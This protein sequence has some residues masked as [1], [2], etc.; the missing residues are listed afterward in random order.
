MGASGDE[1][2]SGVTMNRTGSI[3]ATG[4]IGHDNR[5]GTVRVYNANANWAQA[6][7]DIDGA[8]GANN[9]ESGFSISMNSSGNVIAIGSPGNDK[10]GATETGLDA[11]EE[12]ARAMGIDPNTFYQ[13]DP[14]QFDTIYNNYKMTVAKM[15]QKRSEDAKK[16]S[17]EM[18][19]A[20]PLDAM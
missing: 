3:I 4:A 10:T 7:A 11:E 16:A 19:S 17:G 5:R 15:Q 20:V 9:D 18:R 14:E 12:V 1:L 2:G 8:V 13:M 6:Y